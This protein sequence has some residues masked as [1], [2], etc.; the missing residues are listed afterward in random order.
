MVS[1]E[2][3]IRADRDF[4]LTV[5]GAASPLAMTAKTPGTGMTAR[6]YLDATISAVVIANPSADDAL[7][8]EVLI[9]GD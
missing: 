4:N 3:F 8:V 9:W 5:N 7:N 2:L 6:A 1:L